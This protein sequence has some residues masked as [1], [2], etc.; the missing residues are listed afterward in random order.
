MGIFII[1]YLHLISNNMKQTDTAL[2]SLIIS[3]PSGFYIKIDIQCLRQ[4]VYFDNKCNF[5]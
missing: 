4:H 3:S 2:T 1:L 5:F